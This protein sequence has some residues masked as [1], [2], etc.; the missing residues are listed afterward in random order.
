MCVGIVG[1][2]SGNRL[3]QMKITVII[4]YNYSRPKDIDVHIVVP[5]MNIVYPIE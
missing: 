3:Y 1:G 2:F 5:T 4:C